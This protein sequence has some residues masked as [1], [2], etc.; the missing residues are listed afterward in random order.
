MDASGHRGTDAPDFFSAVSHELRT[1][2][3]SVLG[4]LEIVLEDHALAEDHR[5]HL[6]IAHRCSERLLEVVEQ[7]LTPDTLVSPGTRGP[8][9][10]RLMES[11]PESSS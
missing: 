5:E 2:L 3:T 9:G 8:G 11:W 7:L 10:T 6:E 1:P 4:Y